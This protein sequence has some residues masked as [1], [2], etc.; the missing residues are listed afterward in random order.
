MVEWMKEAGLPEPEYKEE[1]GGFSFHF[2]K[3]IYTEQKFEKYGIKRPAEKGSDVC[4]TLG[5]NYK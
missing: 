3:D 4:K 2:Y 1:M 5:E